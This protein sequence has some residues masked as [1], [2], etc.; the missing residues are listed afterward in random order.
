MPA[1]C[2]NH[3]ASGVQYFESIFWAYMLL[4]D[5]LAIM[6]RV[7]MINNIG[8]SS[9]THYSTQLDLMPRRMRRIFT[10][11]R[12]ELEFPLVHPAEVRVDPSYQQRNY[13]VQAWNNPWR[14]VQYSIEELWLN[15]R[16]GNLTNICRAAI[17]R[18]RI[19]LF[20]RAH[21]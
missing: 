3:A 17:N 4:H 10:M 21:G 16:Q 6:P 19:M 14:K 1:M 13:L 11:K 9:G 5:G 18:L 20:G 8:M 2:Q 7:N 15:M 12:Q